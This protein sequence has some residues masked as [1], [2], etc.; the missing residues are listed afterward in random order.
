MV[1]D[2]YASYVAALQSHLNR[3]ETPTKHGPFDYVRVRG[4]RVD[5]SL[6]VIRMYLY[7]ADI[8]AILTPITAEFDY[9]R[10]LIKDDGFQRDPEL[11]ETT[12]WWIA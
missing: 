9:Q 8:D 1:R 12:K 10:K 2:F 6:P 3:R 5:I 11:R 7:G 4:K